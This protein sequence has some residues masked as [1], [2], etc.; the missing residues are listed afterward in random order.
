ML[1][2]NSYFRI[3]HMVMHQNT[4]RL[5]NAISFVSVHAAEG[6]AHIPGKKLHTLDIRTQRRQL[7]L[8]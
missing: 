2:V 4:P 8:G 1:D 3:H 5:I 7:K 6:V